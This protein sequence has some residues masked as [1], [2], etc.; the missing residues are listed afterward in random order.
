MVGLFLSGIFALSP[1]GV[2][3]KN[4]AT[5]L[6]SAEGQEALLEQRS[7]D[8]AAREVFKVIEGGQAKDNIGEVLNL[9]EVAATKAARK[10]DIVSR[11]DITQIDR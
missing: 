11:L 5:F 8:T 7:R 6:I 4:L 3:A 9:L 1:N 2:S 10:N